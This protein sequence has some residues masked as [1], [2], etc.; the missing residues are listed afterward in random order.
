MATGTE[1]ATRVR[2]LINDVA[3]GFVSGLRW[4]DPELLLWIADAQREIVKM[5]PEANPVTE[6]YT[7]EGG[8]PRQRLSPTISYR[9]IRVE[10]NGSSEGGG[11][12]DATMTFIAGANGSGGIGLQLFSGSEVYGEIL[13][14]EFPGLPD[15]P[16]YAVGDD[17][18]DQA[19]ASNKFSVSLFGI[20]PPTKFTSLEIPELDVV[21]LS[22]NAT[23]DDGSGDGPTSI[24][25]WPTPLGFQDGE[26]YS[27]ILV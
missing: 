10:A 7:V 15:A 8:S 12:A 18:S 21:L 4:T 25:F 14:G 16:T 11:V 5:K 20:F 6:L 27:L 23:F 1:V 22:A 17:M 9:L 24:W 26:T 19:G 2:H 13:T 3:T